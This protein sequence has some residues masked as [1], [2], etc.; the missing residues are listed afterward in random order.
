MY[1]ESITGALKFAFGRA[2]PFENRGAFSFHPFSFKDFGF[3]S[4]PGGHNTEGWAVST[5]L[6]RNAHSKALKIL[7]YTPA[8]LTFIARIY[9]DQHWTSDDFLGAT[10]GF[11]V[12]SWVVNHHEKKKS[13]VNVSAI[14]PFTV[15][16][17]F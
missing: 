8:M 14:Y 15:S 4:L 7:A 16:V 5:V 13:A 10:I 9:E 1:S 2:R 3:Q 6:S 17:S 12:G 11:V